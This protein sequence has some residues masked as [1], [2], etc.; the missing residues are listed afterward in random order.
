[1][2]KA[3]LWKSTGPKKH[4]EWASSSENA[5]ELEDTVILR[6]G[7]WMNYRSGDKTRSATANQAVICLSCS[8]SRSL[9][10]FPL[11]SLTARSFRGKLTGSGQ[12]GLTQGQAR[13]EM[14]RS[15]HGSQRT[16]FVL[17]EGRVPGR[18]TEARIPEKN[19]FI[20]HD[21]AP[22]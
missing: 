16:F 19:Q 15:R 1:M 8:L 22:R 12:Q 6:E 17:A 13:R 3:L 10:L 4:T 11:S 5:G 7:I 20:L 9:L 2:G 14:N 18:R 21:G